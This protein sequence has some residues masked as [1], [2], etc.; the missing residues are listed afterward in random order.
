V[1]GTARAVAKLH[2]EIFSH[3]G[4]A[5]D[6]IYPAQDMDELLDVLT[7]KDQHYQLVMKLL[8]DRLHTITP[9]FLALR[10]VVNRTGASRIA[11][12]RYGVREGYLIEKVKGLEGL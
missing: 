4:D 10:A 9:G 7:D 5:G 12:S 1:G 8:P 11:L 2:K 6:Y 3:P